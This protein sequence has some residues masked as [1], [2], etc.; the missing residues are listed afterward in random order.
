MAYLDDIILFARSV[1]EH[2]E[3]IEIV[4]RDLLSAGLRISPSKAFI[5]PF[6]RMDVLGVT[7]DLLAQAFFVSPSFCLKVK[8]ACEEVLAHVPLVPRRL[9]ESFS[10]KVGFVALVHP[11]LNLKRSFLVHAIARAD[12]DAGVGVQAPV[13][14]IASDALKEVEWWRSEEACAAMREPS[15]WD[16]LPLTRLYARHY[17]SAL[18]PDITLASD[19]SELGVG[20][21]LRDA[22]VAEPLPAELLGTSSTARE[23]Y[24]IARVIRRAAGS[25]LLGG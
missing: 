8:E 16:V 21:R 7:V 15:F 5:L 10:G 9:L 22:V 6:R 12:C 24:A 19:A 13:V 4:V 1:E 23:L 11:Y 3:H 20:L 17:P 25:G 18:S 14:M 2:A